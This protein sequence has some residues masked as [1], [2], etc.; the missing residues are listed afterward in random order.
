MHLEP[1]WSHLSKPCK[2]FVSHQ[3]WNFPASTVA[4]QSSSHRPAP[5]AELLGWV[6]DQWL[7]GIF[8]NVGLIHGPETVVKSKNLPRRRRQITSACI[9]TPVRARL[10]KTN[11]KLKDAGLPYN[12]VQSNS[13]AGL[14]RASK[15]KPDSL[16]QR[17]GSMTVCV[18]Q[19]SFWS[20]AVKWIH[21]SVCLLLREASQPPR[22]ISKETGPMLFPVLQTGIWLS[23]PGLTALTALTERPSILQPP[24]GVL[25]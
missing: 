12:F 16:V 7:T 3:G 4:T 9:L 18:K 8:G 15:M 23:G 10:P 17:D 5:L 25:G 22:I 21:K 19:Q 11:Q 20:V 6:Q 13:R 1:K 2:G 24:A 14:V